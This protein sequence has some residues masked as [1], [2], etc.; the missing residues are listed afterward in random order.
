MAARPRIY[1]LIST[2]G[3]NRSDLPIWQYVSDNLSA[4]TL[5]VWKKVLMGEDD[6]RHYSNRFGGDGFSPRTNAPGCGAKRYRDFTAS[7]RPGGWRWSIGNGLIPDSQRSS[8]RDLRVKV[9]VTTIPEFPNSR[10]RIV[11]VRSCDSPGWPG[12]QTLP[13]DRVLADGF[14]PWVPPHTGSDSTGG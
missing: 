6:K 10:V 8:H 11:P 1:Y 9:T 12:H 7:R 13:W 4:R 14:P 3:V 2:S 5:L